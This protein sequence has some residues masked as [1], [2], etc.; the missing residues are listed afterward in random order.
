MDVNTTKWPT[1]ID[2]LG[3]TTLLHC[4][5]A[6]INFNDKVAEAEPGARSEGQRDRMT[7]GETGSTGISMTSVNP[8]EFR[9]PRLIYQAAPKYGWRFSTNYQK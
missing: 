6:G 4:G 5:V 3:L 2:I 7:T 9:S 1:E 8:S